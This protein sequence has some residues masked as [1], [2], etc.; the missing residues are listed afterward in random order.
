[1]GGVR[2]V[3]IG[4]VTNGWFVVYMGDEVEDR[5]MVAHDEMNG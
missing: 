3:R 1:V 5:S 4:R 2:F